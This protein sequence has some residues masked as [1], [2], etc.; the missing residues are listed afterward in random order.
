MEECLC[1]VIIL[2]KQTTC[3]AVLLVSMCHTHACV[4]KI[5]LFWMY[6]M[7]ASISDGTG[8]PKHATLYITYSIRGC[9]ACLYETVPFLYNYSYL[10]RSQKFAQFFHLAKKLKMDVFYSFN[11]IIIFIK[12][13]F[14]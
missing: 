2:N 14:A 12:R 4:D 9:T 10:N 6:E 7:T 5:S 1:K 8:L 3:S 11:F 13:I